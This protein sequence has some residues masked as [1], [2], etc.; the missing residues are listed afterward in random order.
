MIRLQFVNVKSEPI[1]APTFLKGSRRRFD[2]VVAKATEGLDAPF[3]ASLH[4]SGQALVCTEET[5]RI[6]PM[7]IPKGLSPAVRKEWEARLWRNTIVQRNE[8]VLITILPQGG[9]QGGAGKIAMTLASIAL[10]A[11]AGPLAGLALKGTALAGNA[12]AIAAVQAGIPIGGNI[13]VIELED[14]K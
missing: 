14:A 9:G 2:R 13:H 7:A 4:S 1:D 8:T 6:R 12:F 10:M 5:L 3:M 11:F